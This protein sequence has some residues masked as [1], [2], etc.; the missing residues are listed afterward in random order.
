MAMIE[1]N[2]SLSIDIEEI[3]LQHKSLVDMINRVHDMMSQGQTDKEGVLGI[4]SDMGA[5]AAEHF[6]T[7]E[8]YMDKYKY[9]QAPLHKV[10]HSDFIEKVTQVNKQ[11][12]AGSGRTYMEV[13]NFLT[14]WLVNHINETDK[15]M[16]TFLNQAMKSID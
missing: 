9:P 16:G 10:R 5:Y 7:E 8:R 12:A 15:V 1:W 4:L 3:D 14:D 13:L 2:D 6:S 11:L